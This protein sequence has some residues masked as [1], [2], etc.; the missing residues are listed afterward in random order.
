MAFANPFTAANNAVN[1]WGSGLDNWAAGQTGGFSGGVA[2]AM[3]GTVF[4][5]A[6]SLGTAAWKK[7]SEDKMARNLQPIWG[8]NISL[9]SGAYDDFVKPE[10]A[11]DYDNEGLLKQFHGRQSSVDAYKKRFARSRPKT[12]GMG[13][14]IV[15]SRI[16]YDPEVKEL[17]AATWKRGEKNPNRLVPGHT[18]RRHTFTGSPTSSLRRSPHRKVGI[19]ADE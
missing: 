18:R 16:N 10:P 2:D 12:G 13:M 7:K 14:A 15:R 1:S 5:M 11:I 8:K 3:L 6:G 19:F 9:K 17:M 4:S